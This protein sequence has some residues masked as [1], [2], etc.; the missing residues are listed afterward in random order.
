MKIFSQEVP[1]LV[2]DHEENG[3]G[4]HQ[5]QYDVERDRY[6]WHYRRGVYEGAERD[7]HFCE[8][9]GKGFS[10]RFAGS[11]VSLMGL[12]GPDQG[13]ADCAVDGVSICRVDL[14]S[15]EY[16]AGE[17]F[18][19]QP[20]TAGEHIL[21]VSVAEEKNPL[22]AGRFVSVSSARVTPLLRE[23]ACPLSRL[24]AAL[25]AAGASPSGQGWLFSRESEAELLLYG[26]AFRFSWEGTE[27]IRVIGGETGLMEAAG[28]YDAVFSRNGYH[29]VRLLVPAGTL[30]LGI[31]AAQSAECDDY[32]Q[33]ARQGAALSCRYEGAWTLDEEAMG[34][35]G[36]CRASAERFPASVSLRFLGAQL[37]V[38]GSADAAVLARWEIDGQEFSPAQPA[39]FPL[40]TPLLEEGEHTASITLLG[41]G[42]AELGRW[43]LLRFAP[44][45]GEVRVLPEQTFQEI[46]GFG[47][48]SGWTIN[49]V[50]KEWREENR[51]K[52]ADYL[53]DAEKGIGLTCFRY[54]LGAGSEI[55]DNERIQGEFRWRKTETFKAAPD[56]PYD[57]S[58]NSGL[59]WMMQAARERGADCFTAYIHS[60]PFWMTV[61]GHTQGDRGER[62]SNLLPGKEGELAAFLL[63]ILAHFRTEM[64]LPFDY[65]SPV[66]EPGWDWQ[67]PG[68]HEEGCH[69]EQDEVWRVLTAVREEMERRG[70]PCELLGPEVE[71]V[72]ALTRMLPYMTARE[73]CREVLRGN[74]TAHSYYTD[75]F[76]E[77]GICCRKQLQ[78]ALEK[79]GTYRYWQ[80]E[81]CLIGAGRGECRDYGI[82]PAL[83]LAQ[84]VHYDMTLL[85]ACSWQWWLSL[86]TGDFDYK[87]GLVYSDW[88]YPGDEENVL[89][90][91]MLWALGQYSRFIRRGD[92]RAACQADLP[93]DVLVSAYLK[94]DAGKAVLVF[95]NIASADRLIRLPQARETALFLTDDLPG[96]DIA[97]AD[98]YRCR[99]TVV[100]PRQSVMT[101]LVTL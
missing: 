62:C 36:A 39:V 58:R 60:A 34:Y 54:D 69:M 45:E 95:V 6:F 70:E 66:N 44:A 84:T 18:S 28:A 59:T 14:Y 33:H 65:I 56:A 93:D 81:Y 5:F 48:S 71:T 87:D 86:S 67:Y 19:F 74:I 37:S 49:P 20:E 91:K 12:R 38:E 40:R 53:Y 25:R 94:K 50:C 83:W 100:I 64:K 16:A 98:Q 1:L 89:P 23:N 24:E 22:S 96:R 27:K 76:E 80:T 8:L 101:A 11:T 73:N 68:V 79:A 9:P 10:F 41:E 17:I 26:M 47:A 55:S 78:R 35:L 52:I 57:F 77:M 30:L 15:P 29:C 7:D 75:L 46:V 97:P 63:D 82:M 72:D 43:S 88:R 51:R 21:R 85:N 90:S 42:H 2:F 92:R 4:L 31:T 99:D 61:N 32:S 3:Y 13:M